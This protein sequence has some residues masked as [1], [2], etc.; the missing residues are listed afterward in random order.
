MRKA[1]DNMKYSLFKNGFKMSALAFTNKVIE[2]G[3]LLGIDE[4]A[5]AR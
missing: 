5:R 4:Q 1:A 2:C 3:K